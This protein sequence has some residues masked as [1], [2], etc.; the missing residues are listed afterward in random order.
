MFTY[1]L[2]DFP[3][4]RGFC[5]RS[6][7]PACFRSG[8]PSSGPVCGG[9]SKGSR[10]PAQAPPTRKTSRARNAEPAESRR[11]SSPPDSGKDSAAGREKAAASPCPAHETDLLSR[12]TRQKPAARRAPQK[13]KC[14]GENASGKSRSPRSEKWGRGRR[15]RASLCHF[16]RRHS[17]P[18]SR[19]VRGLRPGEN[20]QV[21]V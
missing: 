15:P 7:G 4:N 20:L 2:P 6:V 19:I 18:F 21:T 1:D 14:T 17:P 10:A 11:E 5:S 13:Q 12:F 9:L 8:L 16:V 3:L